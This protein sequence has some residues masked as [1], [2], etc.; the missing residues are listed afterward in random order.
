[1]EMLKKK[2]NTFSVTLIVLCVILA[3]YTVILM[4]PLLWALY[5]S[6]MDYTMYDLGTTRED[7][8]MMMNWDNLTWQNL[9][10][11]FTDFKVTISGGTHHITEMF[12]Y[13]IL[14]SG[15][16]AIIA[17][18]VPCVMAYL[19]ARFNFFFGKIVYGIVLL[20]MAIPIVGSLPSEI[21]MIENL[22]LMDSLWGLYVLRANFLGIYFLVF[23]AQFK[24]IPKDYT[25]AAELDG[26]SD[27]HI[28]V[29]I[30]FPIS[31][32]TIT[33]VMLLNFI[34]YWNDYQIPMI[35]W[36]SH[37]VMAYG[38]YYFVRYAYGQEGQA[39]TPVHVSSM[40][41]VAIP[42]LILFGIFNKKIMSNMSVGGVKG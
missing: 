41:L 7:L 22:N 14:Y 2:K 13:S 16:C 38:M 30:I 18:M 28:M 39:T 12:L 40:M 11:A 8:K 37:P 33:T 10:T 6:F 35:Y 20:T 27:W 4:I 19:V 24:G 15:G 32:G 23:Y 3:L 17:T 42:I 34:S 29:K 36:S 1:M 25:E 5:T 31:V 21:R 9:I 26:A